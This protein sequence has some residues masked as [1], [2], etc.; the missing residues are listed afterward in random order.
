MRDH[1]DEDISKQ[2]SKAKRQRDFDDLQNEISGADTGRMRKFLSP[3]DDRSPDGKRRKAE[4]ER[5][6]RTLEELMRDPEYAALYTEFGDRLRGAET[7]ADTALA[8]IER[9]LESAHQM[10]ADLEARAARDPD[11]RLV[12]QH[13]DGRVV[14]ADGSDVDPAIAEGIIWPVDAPSSEDYFAAQTQR[15]A[16]EDKRAD[17][18]TYRN[19]VLGDMRNRYDSEDPAMSLDDLKRDLDRIQR[20]NPANIS[21]EQ[22]SAPMDAPVVETAAAISV[23]MALK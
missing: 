21:L 11:G 9:Q 6:R 23:P 19:D 14:Y 5:T 22:D 10:I 7:E 1:T 3:N 20:L 16:L 18:G 8:M 17:W 15:Q 12:F 2:L 4:R 13:A